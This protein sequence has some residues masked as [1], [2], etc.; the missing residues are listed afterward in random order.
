[1]AAALEQRP[2]DAL[3]IEGFVVADGLGG[4][5]VVGHDKVEARE[6]SEVIARASLQEE[7]VPLSQLDR[8]LEEDGCDQ[9][10][11][12]VEDDNRI[13]LGGKRRHALEYA[14]LDLV[15]KRF[16]RKD[17]ETQDLSR[18]GVLDAGADLAIG[19]GRLLG[20]DDDTACVD[21]L[22][23]ELCQQLGAVRVISDDRDDGNLGSEITDRRSEVPRCARCRD[24]RAERDDGNR[25][26]LR[27]VDHLSLDVVVEEEVTDNENP[28]SRE[29]LK[30]CEDFVDRSRRHHG[31]NLTA[32]RW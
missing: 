23:S 11:D 32:L 13:R 22:F 18:W 17:V 31:W 28:V 21:S 27:D 24:S 20:V 8:A 26:F 14:R 5:P 29:R 15:A 25:P 16:I 2:S 12:L 3:G 10:V 1:M 9:V 6:A 30:G 19:R 7:P 4:L